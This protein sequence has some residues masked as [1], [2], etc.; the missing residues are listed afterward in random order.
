MADSEIID[1]VNATDIEVAVAKY[2]NWRVNLIVPNVSW[3]FF[4]HECDLLIVTKAGYCYEVEIKISRADLKADAKKRHGHR[5]DRLRKLFF[6]IPGQMLSSIDLIPSHA[7]VFSVWAGGYCKKER[8]AQTLPAQPISES[9]RFQVAR[10]GT[11]RIWGLKQ[12]VTRLEDKVAAI[13]SP[14]SQRDETVQ[15]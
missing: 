4:I 5:S 12:K 3:G 8:E 2:F 7:G 11:M 9:E 10:L 13:K 6:A 1:R 14:N 15:A